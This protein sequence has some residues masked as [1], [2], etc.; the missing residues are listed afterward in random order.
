MDNLIILHGI[1]WD[2]DED[3]P[4][5]YLF[6]YDPD[7]VDDPIEAAIEQAS[8]DNGF[9]II[10]VERVITATDVEMQHRYIV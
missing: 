6:S 3:L 2:S 4:V 5:T 10:E 8:E 1:T 9:C 7:E